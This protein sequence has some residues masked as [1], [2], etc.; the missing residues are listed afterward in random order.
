MILVYCK[1]LKCSK[2]TK[3][4]GILEAT[5]GASL[6]ENILAEKGVLRG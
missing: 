3:G 4:G 6:L 1:I 2:R 5:L